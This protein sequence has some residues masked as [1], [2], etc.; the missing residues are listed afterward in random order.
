MYLTKS[1]YKVAR[2]CATKLYYRK[3]GQFPN[4]T[5]DEYM[6]LL[7]EGGFMVEEI[8]RQ[9]HPGGRYIGFHGTPEQ[10]AERT[11]HEIEQGDCVLFEATFVA[12][13]LHARVDVLVRR[14]DEVHLI[15][16]KSAS[17][18]GDE[19]RARLQA[20]LPGVMRGKKPPH[21][22]VDKW[23]PHVE[24]VA[25]QTWVARQ[26]L[27]GWHIRPFLMMPDRD[28]RTELDGLWQWFRLERAPHGGRPAV[29][30]HGDAEALR[31]KPFL[32]KVDISAEV[33]LV[34]GEVIGAAT[35]FVTSLVPQP[36]PILVPISVKC[37]ECEL[38]DETEAGDARLFAGCWG[39]L[40]D[41]RPNLFDIYSVAT[42]GGLRSPVANRL[43][44]ERRVR[45]LDMDE[46]HLVKADGSV[47]AANTRQLIQLR[48]TR[49]NRE[50][51]SE[52]FPR[53]LDGFTYP[54]HFIDFETS[55]LAI[56]YHA[57]MRPYEPVAYQWSCHTVPHP[58][59]APVHSEW[60]N[61][62]DAFPNREFAETLRNTV[63]D[64][65]TVFMW[66]THERTILRKIHSQLAERGEADADVCGWAEELEGRLVDMNKLT[67]DHYFHPRMGGRTSIKYVVRA[68]W[69]ENPRVR[70]A[71]PEYDGPGAACLY[72]SLPA[73][74][75]AGAPFE[76]RE[77]TA[78]VRAYQ[79]MMYGAE[80]RDAVA[81][82]E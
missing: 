72:G 11:R 21:P 71:F 51:V 14:G 53:I 3:T 27:P 33:E 76:V 4:D 64:A 17:F 18:P 24:D 66:A 6:R 58:G 74:E 30:F 16:V 8:A 45:L 38:H 42:I 22:L 49:I 10:A 36:R 75:I 7:A 19:H 5:G 54:L 15:E 70:D 50:W 34:L 2:T 47:G 68:V 52:D 82:E 23:P 62:T 78:A 44:N 65:G 32:A 39:D 55:A 59:A 13:A 25:F 60:I 26:A 1:D 67:F 31:R 35:E 61:S 48:N 12:G 28:A 69:A 57:G 79:A 63:G 9:M 80:S 46:A 81:R 40:A 41:V 29:T 77:G 20:G 56:P 43:I 37:R 73:V